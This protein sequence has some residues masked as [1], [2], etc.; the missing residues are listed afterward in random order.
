MRFSVYVPLVACALV[1]AGAPPLVRG[2]RPAWAARTL[3]L[4]AA[5]LTATYIWGLVLL[6]GVFIGQAPALSERAGY[7]HRLLGKLDPVPDL[8]SVAAIA[9]LVIAVAG[10]GRWA[11]TAGRRVRTI[12]R[13]LATDPGSGGELQVLPD[14]EPFAAAIAGSFGRAGRIVVSVGMLRS[15]DAAERRVL[16][17]HERSHLARRHHVYE[18]ISGLAAAV[19]PMLGGLRR[20]MAFTLERWADEDAAAATGDR[21]L[22]AQAISRA[23][24]ATMDPSR[25][26]IATAGLGL[27]R[28]G[29]TDRVAALSTEPVRARR[30]PVLVAAAAFSAAALIAT[31]DATISFVHLL[32]GAGAR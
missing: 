3:G 5:L 12:R 10:L 21:Q 30:L 24:L 18:A 6:A 23:A 7:S 17:A 11:A 4:S 15:L 29:V 32:A 1:A 25:S 8:A 14:D 19:N 27:E 20:A 28:L 26:G 22:V 9:V 13:I 2:W 31:S 16:L